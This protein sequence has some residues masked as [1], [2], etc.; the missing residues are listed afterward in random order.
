[1]EQHKSVRN[2]RERKSSTTPCAVAELPQ[3]E[4]LT[5]GD[6]DVQVIY[7]ASIQTL[8][9]VGVTIAHA[10]SLLAAILGIDQQSPVLVNG[11]P[12]RTSYKIAPADAV[13]VIHHAGEKG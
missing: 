8:P 9:L 12:V 7:G 10:R 6:T 3:H 5:P 13:E 2:E 1:M 11:R 4:T